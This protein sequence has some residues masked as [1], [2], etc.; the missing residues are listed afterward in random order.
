[1]L[2][3]FS[4][5]SIVF[6]TLFYFCTVVKAYDFVNSDNEERVYDAIKNIYDEKKLYD[7]LSG[8]VDDEEIEIVSSNTYW[9]PIG[10][11]EVVEKDG[12]L[13]AV[14][15]PRTVNTS[16]G[17][18]CT[19]EN[20]WR[21]D[22]CHGG[23]DMG[24]GSA[25]GIVNVIAS[26]DGVVVYP[27]AEYQ[28]QF[29][30]HGF[31]GNTEGGGYGNYVVILHADGIYTVYGH[32]AKDSI[33]VMA[34]ETVKQGQVIAKMGHSGSSTGPHL[35]FTVG[36][37]GI[38]RANVVDPLDYIDPENPRP[39]NF[40][41]SLNSTTLSKSEFV[42]KMN[43]YCTRT[44]R[45]GFCNNFASQAAE[46]YDVSL[47]NNV[48]PE[49][50]VVKAGA[51]SGW[52]L[53]GNCAAANNYWGIRIYNGNS[54][55]SGGVYDTL[56]DGIVDYAKVIANY[57]PNG[58]LAQ[59]ITERYNECE[60]AGCDPAGHGLPGTMEGMQSVYSWIGN[61]RYYKGDPNIGGCYYFNVIY[62]EEYCKSKPVCTDY[63]NC[64][65][66]TKTTPCEQNDY[67]IFRLKKQAAIRYDI[68]GL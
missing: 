24:D 4:K 1:M 17:F 20:A 40:G 33:T 54:C 65:A 49:L 13:Y 16:N 57:S 68:F 21:T 14:G 12:V 67:T 18:G 36:I 59:M 52:D 8:I 42:A 10:S 3:K 43:N 50:V 66:E 61:Y 37:G 56:L 15:A 26:K 9:W 41:F 60:A 7:E 58:S 25:P 44:G 5:V 51:E 55:T 38:G 2:K 35:H 64:P 45:T 30:D 63:S 22:G 47:R 46:I 48:N 29:E 11:D 34:G 53:K 23:L 31:Y 19:A 27:T 32:L 62:G 6:I 39:Q 28:K